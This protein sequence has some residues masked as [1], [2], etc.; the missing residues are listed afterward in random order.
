MQS[1]LLFCWRLCGLAALLG[2]GSG[3]N[4]GPKYVRPGVATPQGFKESAPAAFRDLP[5]GTWQPARPADAALKGKW[6]TIFGEPE[7]DA[8]EDRLNIDNQT[9]AQ[10]FQ[11]LMAARAQVDEARAGYY[12]TVSTAPSFTRTTSGAASTAFGAATASGTAVAPGGLASSGGGGLTNSN[13]FTIPA[14]ASWAPD[15]WQRVRNTVRQ[16]Q[17]AAQ[18]SAADLE[19]ERLTEQASLA[20]FYFE[21]RGQDALVDLYERTVKAD[22]QSLD[23]TRAQYETGIGT[24]ESVAQAE[25]TLE[26]AQATGVGLAIN[27][28]LFEHAI[29]TLIGKP[30][31]DFSLPV[32][33][34]T[35]P[36]PA[37]P[38]GIPSQLLQRRPDVAAAERTLAEANALIGVEK[39]AFYPSIDLTSTG[40]LASSALGSLFSAP[41]LF[42]S[43]GVSASETIFDGGL[44]RATVAQYNAQYKADVAAYRQTVLTA[45]QQVEDF[46]ATLRILSQQIARQEVAVKSA[47]R[48]LDVSIAS[49][50]TGITPYLD[51]TTAQ[52]LL[53]T[54]QQTLVTLR[55]NEMTAA[56]EL[57]Q[58]LG[59]GWEAGGRDA[60]MLK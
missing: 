21:L 10:F 22:Q 20:E 40:G 4:V 1:S 7:L 14:T 16:F 50:E 60:A 56:V 15:L 28:A 29:A 17:A 49:Y 38:V 54:D 53:L 11:N 37:I 55:V 18:V 32:K 59:G 12:P 9:I 46:V 35:T 6:W 34:L 44:R 41:S 45:F 27:R 3:C 57:V 33:V 26:N 52:A 51:V 23:Y 31:S 30:A 42:W 39:A 19:N 47:Q 8:L 25:V 48:N 36:V 43:L 2:V 24:E 5:P 58:A 13:F